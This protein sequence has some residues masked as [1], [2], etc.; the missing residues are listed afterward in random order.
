MDAFHA[1]AVDGFYAQRGVTVISMELTKYEPT[2]PSTQA[3]LQA[4]IEESTNRINMLAQQESENE[5]AAAKL[6]AD[7]ELERQKTGL[8]KTQASNE[9]L[10][11]R[12][13]GEAAGMELSKEAS[14]FLDTLSASM[15]ESSQRLE[16]YKL[17]KRLT[18]QNKNTKSL[19]DGQAT[20][21]LTPNDMNLRL[22]M[23]GEGTSGSLNSGSDP[24]RLSVTSS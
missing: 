1:Q 16:L 14:S 10:L 2:D 12:T 23:G 24:R 17:H 19:A 9:R 13:Q 11:A 7:I 3:V 18:A 15:P 20:L 22:H 6:Q 4:I 21:F 8:I 5:V